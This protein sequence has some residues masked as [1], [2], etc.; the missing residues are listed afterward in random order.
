M[1]KIAIST[2]FLFYIKRSKNVTLC[3]VT[4][5]DI[6]ILVKRKTTERGDKHEIRKFLWVYNITS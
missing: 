2:H 5:F 1:E 6:V 4:V 3:D